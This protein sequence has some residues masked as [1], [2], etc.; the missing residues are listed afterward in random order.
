[1][2]G[3]PSLYKCE[4]CLLDE[5]DEECYHREFLTSGKI[6]EI[7]AAVKAA[8]ESDLLGTGEHDQASSYKILISRR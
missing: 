4:D 1:M 5:I 2:R 3:L 8:D 7:E 6:K